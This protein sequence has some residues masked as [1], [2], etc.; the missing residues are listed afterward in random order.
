MKKHEHLRGS[1]YK[2]LIKIINIIKNAYSGLL[3]Y[4]YRTNPENIKQ[5][6]KA[7]FEKF[8]FAWKKI[9]E[10]AILRKTTFKVSISKKTQLRER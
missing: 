6:D 10:N 4:E 5:I 8:H 3:Q 9:Y 2:N 1:S 7:I